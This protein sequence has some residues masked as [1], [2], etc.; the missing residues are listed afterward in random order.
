MADNKSTI[1]DNIRARVPGV[2]DGMIALELGNCVY[3]F[4][5]MTNVWQEDV[6]LTTQPGVLTY[7]VITVDGEPVRLM[8]V[9]NDGRRIQC[10]FAPPDALSFPTDLNTVSLVAT[11]ALV[12]DS[13]DALNVPEWLWLNYRNALIEG[14][15]GRLMS[16]I[17]KPYA[18][19]RMAI[20]HMRRFRNFAAQARV[21][22][23]RQY[24]YAAQA[25]A[26]P[27]FS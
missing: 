27:K 16:Q 10:S 17:A 5:E 14:T 20:Y 19:E 18:N 23:Q 11:F 4:L 8:G 25:W 21:E 13:T 3:E 9:K 12:P 7:S 26:F 24:N 2:L 15:L 1:I 22:A 6:S